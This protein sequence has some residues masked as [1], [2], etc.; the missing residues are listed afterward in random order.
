MHTLC[1]RVIGILTFFLLFS[2][3]T[4]IAKASTCTYQAAFSQNHVDVLVQTSGGDPANINI[5]VS[6]VTITGWQ[7]PGGTWDDT[8]FNVLYSDYQ[9]GWNHFNWNLVGNGIVGWNGNRNIVFFYYPNSPFP[10]NTIP[11]GIYGINLSGTISNLSEVTAYPAGESNNVACDYIG[12]LPDT[13][14]AKSQIVVVMHVENDNGGN[15]TAENFTINVTGTNVTNTSFEG[16]ETGTTVILDTGEY[17]IDENESDGY[18]KILG[19]NCSGTITAGETKTCI[20]TNDDKAPTVTLTKNI[21]NNIGNAEPNDFG[22]NISGNTVLSGSTTEVMANTPISINETG[23]TNYDFVSIVGTNCPPQLGDEIILSSGQNLNCTI[24][25]NYTIPPTPTPTPITKVFV[26][27]GLG[28]SWNVDALINCRGSDH[29]GTWILAPYAKDV[30]QNI[31]KNLADQHWN[32]IPFYYDWRKDIRDNSIILEN[33]INSNVLEEEKVDL[34]GHSMGG[35]IGRNYLETKNG[36]KISKFFAVGT[37]NQG[38]AF[39]YPALVNNNIWIDDLIQK[40]ATTLLFNHCGVPPSLKN[41]LPTYSYLRNNRTK[42]LKDIS[43][44]KTKNNYLPT[45]FVSDF[46]GVKVGTLAGTGKQTIEIIDVASDFR[47]P[48]GKPVGKETS[49]SGDGTVLVSSAQIPGAFS[50]ELINQSH[51]GIIASDE[52]VDKILKFLG[53]PGIDDPEYVEHKSALILVSYPGKFSI[54]DKNGYITE[55]EDGVIAIM[56]PKSE[57]YQLQIT[58]TSN[59]TTFIVGQFLANGQTEYNEYKIRGLNLEPKIIEFDS[60]HTNK[61]PVHEIKR[62]KYPIHFKTWFNFWRSWN[63]PGK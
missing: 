22:I 11:Q 57:S 49:N 43:Q 34:V 56:D 53:S 40:I 35:L 62:Y 29:S 63:K 2:Y 25:N 39:A 33:L 44:M 12:E 16:S 54:A 50:N 30:Y 21:T 4:R 27:P 36:G 17:S 3:S 59:T 1:S 26:I 55:S 28:A 24:T 20:I 38:S 14:S 60:N 31:L 13:T 5:Y 6:G 19:E 45:N 42:E 18:L 8:G 51:S 37:P 61:N 15:A 9:G 7:V 46:W 58:P 52:G 48:D 10:Q 41:L 32:A 47:W 23:M